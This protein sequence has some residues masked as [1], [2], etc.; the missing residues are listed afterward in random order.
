MVYCGC[1]DF[2]NGKINNSPSY[3]I[4][5]FNA[6]SYPSYL[7]CNYTEPNYAGTNNSN[8]IVRTSVGTLKSQVVNYTQILPYQNAYPL[9][10]TYTAYYLQ[11]GVLILS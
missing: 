8:I 9:P 6:L 4:Y 3:I 11:L 2:Y 7:G 1:R 10:P 5:E